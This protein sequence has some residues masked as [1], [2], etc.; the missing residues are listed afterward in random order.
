M[1]VIIS[2]RVKSKDVRGRALLHKCCRDH[3][4]ARV[5]QSHPRLEMALLEDAAALYFA[6]PA[7]PH[8]PRYRDNLD[9]G[10]HAGDSAAPKH[11]FCVCR[12]ARPVSGHRLHVALQCHLGFLLASVAH[13]MQRTSLHT[14]L[15]GP[16]APGQLPEPVTK[17]ILRQQGVNIHQETCPRHVFARKCIA[18]QKKKTGRQAKRHMNRRHAHADSTASKTCVTQHAA[19]V[20]MSM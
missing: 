18:G 6:P 3:P 14:L 13:R 8:P 10:P 5:A 20:Y 9:A 4:A 12:Q 7:L 11:A 19:C 1:E 17:K 2:R 16:R 15:E